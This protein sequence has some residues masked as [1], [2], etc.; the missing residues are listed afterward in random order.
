MSARKHTDKTFDVELD[1][2]R[3]KL[4]TLG[5]KVEAEI[6][7]GVRALLERDSALAESVVASDREVNRLEVEIDEICRRLLALRQPAASDLRLITTA[8]KVV[9]DLERIG[10]LAVNVAE[11]AIDQK[12][13]PPLG[14]L[15]DAQ[16]PLLDGPDLEADR[17]SPAQAQ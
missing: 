15:P 5:G 14:P 3:G 16:G 9:V 17:P 6:A 13:S 8:L 12:Q 7:N 1:E 11:R 4:L 10:D 2:L